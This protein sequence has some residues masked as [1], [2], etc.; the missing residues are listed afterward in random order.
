ME[1]IEEK[2]KELEERI[3]KLEESNI[4]LVNAVNIL[5]EVVKEGYPDN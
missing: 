2:I 3:Q 4:A 5:M 1:N